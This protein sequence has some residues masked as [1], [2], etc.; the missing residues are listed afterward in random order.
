MV[1]VAKMVINDGIGF[2][3]TTY[4]HNTIEILKMLCKAGTDLT[5]LNSENDS[6]LSFVLTHSGSRSAAEFYSGPSKI[7]K[8][9]CKCRVDVNSRHYSQT[10]P[11]WVEDGNTPLHIAMAAPQATIVKGSK[12]VTTLIHYGMDVNS[13]NFL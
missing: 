3:H 11:S 1:I 8:M 12:N 13:Q 5:R 4:H 7:V 6:I 10:M 2:R 9:L